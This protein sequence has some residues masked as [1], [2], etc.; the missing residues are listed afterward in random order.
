MVKK[1]GDKGFITFL[2]ATVILVLAGLYNAELG[3]DFLSPLATLISAILAIFAVAYN[4]WNQNRLADDARERKFIAAKASLSGALI[5]ISYL[6][7]GYIKYLANGSNGTLDVRRISE[8]SIESIQLVIEHAEKDYRDSLIFLL[9]AYQYLMPINK[10]FKYTKIDWELAE[11]N[12][13]Q[14]LSKENTAIRII[15][16]VSY[17]ALVDFHS[18][19]ARTYDEIPNSAHMRLHFE[20][21]LRVVRRNGFWLLMKDEIFQKKFNEAIENKESGFFNPNYFSI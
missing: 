10:D 9:R 6:C 2:L 4:V 12:K 21:E 16:W 19:C 17:K 8:N 18:E 3:K 15:D 5:D 7:D 13:A 11:T 14:E 20:Y 1:L